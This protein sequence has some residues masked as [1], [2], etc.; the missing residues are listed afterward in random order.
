MSDQQ[1]SL[2]MA[3]GAVASLVMGI[4]S[5]CTS[6][7][8]AGIVFAII[9]MVLGGKAKKA[10]AANPSGYKA[11]GVAKTGHILSIVG[12]IVSIIASI[13]FLVVVI[14]GAAM[15]SAANS[16]MTQ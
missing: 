10:I 4:L 8:F 5:L 16:M 6:Y 14:L 3:P 1:K 15:S 7:I 2:P 13:I 11:A 12:L 9:G